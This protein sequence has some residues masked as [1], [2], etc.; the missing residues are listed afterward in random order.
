[1]VRFRHLF[2][3]RLCRWCYFFRKASHPEA[4]VGDG[5]F[6]L[7]LSW[8]IYHKSHSDCARTQRNKVSGKTRNAQQEAVV[9]PRL[10]RNPFNHAHPCCRR[11]SFVRKINPQNQEAP[12][13]TRGNRSLAAWVRLRSEVFRRLFFSARPLPF[14]ALNCTP[15]RPPAS[16]FP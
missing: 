7:W 15:R 10:L 12:A 2:A 14:P 3:R 13:P 5:T 16:S 6:D 9:F 4:R 1:M 8:C 11:A